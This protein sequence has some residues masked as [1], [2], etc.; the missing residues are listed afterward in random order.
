MSSNMVSTLMK[1]KKDWTPPNWDAI[2][3]QMKEEGR[4]AAS[5]DADLKDI[6]HDKS[7]EQKGTGK[8]YLSIVSIDVH[9]SNF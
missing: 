2:M 4:D 3:D 6:M 5:M 9:W 7:E 1:V 8:L